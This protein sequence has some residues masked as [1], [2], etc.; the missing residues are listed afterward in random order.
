MITQTTID[1]FCT[2]YAKSKGIIKYS[3]LRNIYCESYRY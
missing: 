1:N 2:V 3:K